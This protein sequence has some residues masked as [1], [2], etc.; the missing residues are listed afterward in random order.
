MSDHIDAKDMVDFI[1]AKSLDESIMK[2]A[3]KIN[4]HLIECKKCREQYN[5]IFEILENLKK[6]E[7]DVLDKLKI[8]VLRAIKELEISTKT[9]NSQIQEIINNVNDKK[10]E[11]VV[12]IKN[13][14]SI[15][16]VKQNDIYNF[17]HPVSNMSMVAKSFS[18]KKVEND[19]ENSLSNSILEDNEFSNVIT[20]DEDGTFTIYLDK[21]DCPVKSTIVLVS[22]DFEE[23]YASVVQEYDNS[24]N[25]AEFFNIIPNEYMVIKN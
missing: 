8:S 3:I 5:E 25:K 12:N 16:I 24:K 21:T 19:I 14:S 6:D 15:D 7:L 10:D 1:S 13:Y 11:L 2:N 4:K 22:K 9:V 20:I 23:Q 18:D 17:I